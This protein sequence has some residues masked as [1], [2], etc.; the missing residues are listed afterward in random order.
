MGPRLL[1]YISVL[2]GQYHMSIRKI[3][4]LLKDQY[5]IHFSIG[6]ISEAQ[7]RVSA[8]LTPIHQALKLHIHN[9]AVIHADETSHQRN[10]EAA[11][12]WVWLMSGNDAVFQNVRFF[13]SQDNAKHLLG[14]TQATVVTDQ[15]ASYNWLDPQRHQFCWAHVDRNLQQMADFSGKGLTALIGTRLVLICKSV[16]RLQHRFDSGDIDENRWRHRMQRLRRS[17]RH[18]LQRGAL[19]PTTRYSGRCKHILKYEAGLWVFLNHPGIPLTNNEAERCLRG[20][21]I[22]RK[23]CYGTSSDRGDKFR[24]RLLSVVETCKKRSLSPLTI[25]HDIVD[26]VTSKREYPDVFGL[27]SI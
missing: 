11:T 6:A 26:A 7:G 12:R 10:G 13:R 17:M 5:G 2:S 19:V 25:V 8:M 14:A 16:F 4:R 1:S 23:I 9:A 15:C 21:V 27:L 18:W 3:Q 20:S 22:M 24:S